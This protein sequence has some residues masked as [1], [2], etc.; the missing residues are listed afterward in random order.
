MHADVDQFQ[1]VM[2]NFRELFPEDHP[3]SKLL[4][5]IH[6]LDLSSFDENYVN[7]SSKG[8]RKAFPVDRLLA[9]LIYSILHGNI[10]MRNLERDLSQR[11]DLLYL[12]GGLSLDHSTI[13]V[14]RKR[15]A[16]AIEELF[17][18]T[19]FLGYEAGLIDFDSVCI[20]STKI[21]A[22]ANRRDIG[23]QEELQKRYDYIEEACQKRYKEWESLSNEDDKKILQKK[24]DRMSKQ[25]TRINQGIKFLKANKDRK[26]IHLTDKDADWQKGNAGNFIVGYNAHVAVDSKADLIVHNKVVTNQADSN[27]TVALIENVESIKD[28]VAPKKEDEPKYILDSGYSNK[29]NLESLEDKDVY[30]PDQEYASKTEGKTKPEDRKEKQKQEEL[31]KAEVSNTE[32][33]FIYQPETDTFTCPANEELTFKREKLKKDTL[34]RTYRKSGCDSC[35]M[36]NQCIG[37]KAKMKEILIASHNYDDIRKHKVKTIRP[38]G[39]AQGGKKESKHPLILKMREKLKSLQGRKVYALRFP[40][41]EGSIGVIK[42]AR[43]GD[44]FLRRGLDRVQVEWNERCI[45]HNL[46]KIMQFTRVEY[47]TL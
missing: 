14:F 33:K 46:A 13:S 32:L 26:R 28:E 22:S 2:L 30:M 34:Y 1:M 19:V 40:V 47:R 43:Q 3:T 38:H 11:A 41:V 35:F 6:Q 12:S 37:E 21:K 20:D 10:S 17:T 36:K 42:A 18:Q 24:I 23:T 9:I 45:A 29:K 31:K 7:S 8:G 16:K 39:F 27:Q 5:I 44:K 25:Q 15:H 4:D